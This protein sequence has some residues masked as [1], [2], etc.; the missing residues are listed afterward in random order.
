MVPEILGTDKSLS[1][2]DTNGTIV[3]WTDEGN[4]KKLKTL[5]RLNE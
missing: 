4:K 5:K 3:C 2:L 1:S